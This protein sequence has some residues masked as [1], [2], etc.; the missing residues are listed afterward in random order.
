M[1]DI[2]EEIESLLGELES[3]ESGSHPDLPPPKPIKERPDRNN[4]YDYDE[5]DVW[6]RVLKNRN[7][8]LDIICKRFGIR[9]KT[10]LVRRRKLLGLPPLPRGRKH[11]IQYSDA[12]RI[13]LKWLGKGVS[14]KKIAKALRVSVNYVGAI[15]RG[16][17]T[18][19]EKYC[20]TCKGVGVVRCLGCD[21]TPEKHFH[22]CLDC[23]AQ[24][25]TITDHVE[26]K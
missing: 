8:I 6:L 12:H 10:T 19:K 3:L 1:G 11:S 18:P 25:N 24:S 16:D 5:I 21:I 15:K 14:T 23:G 26:R 4:K 2:R 20:P 9:S 7:G 13:A 17:I 22:I